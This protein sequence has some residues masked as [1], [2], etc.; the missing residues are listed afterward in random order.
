VKK[1]EIKPLLKTWL[2]KEAHIATYDNHT[3]K[4]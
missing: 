1:E 3:K 4:P 2:K